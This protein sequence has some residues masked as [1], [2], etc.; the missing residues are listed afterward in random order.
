MILGIDIGGTYSDGVLIKDKQIVK[1]VKIKTKPDNLIES[2]EGIKK[3]AELVEGQIKKLVVSTTL[4]TNFI[5]EKK[6][7][8]TGLLLI[9][10]PGM[11]YN[12]QIFP[13]PYRVISGGVDFQGRLFADLNEK[14]VDLAIRELAAMGIKRISINA[15]FSPRNP[16]LEDKA[17]AYAEKNF[18]NLSFE[19]GSDLTGNLNFIRRA[20]SS[21]LK[22]ASAQVYQDFLQALQEVFPQVEEIR[23]LKSD[24]GSVPI[25]ESSSYSVDTIFSGPAASAFGALALMRD[26]K[27]AVVIDI[28]GTTSDYSLILEGEPLFATKGVKI[29]NF[30]TIARG[31]SLYSTPLGGDS[32]IL[33]FSDNFVFSR[34]RGLPYME[35]GSDL[36]ISDCLL[37]LNEIEIGNKEMALAGL[38]KEAE[39]INLPPQELAE[40]ILMQAGKI[41]IENLKSVIDYWEREPKYR[42]WQ[43]ENKM[44]IHPDLLFIIGGPAKGLQKYIEANS[45]IKVQTDNRAMTANALGAALAKD[46][47]NSFVRINTSEEMVSTGWGYHEEKKFKGR[48]HPDEASLYALSIGKKHLEEKNISG[49]LAVFEHEIFSIVRH[50]YT[51]GQIHEIQIGLPPGIRGGIEL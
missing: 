14:E 11:T 17:L 16:Y 51:D 40:K 46:S 18:P 12:D 23:I 43:I 36:T 7:D 10:G 41:I 48:I 21:G 8:H 20:V 33:L 24:G 26:I 35:G 25:E 38:A 47:F 28:G 44:K 49:E 15:K 6:Y 30:Y 19:K 22:M 37:C 9:P 2:I 1:Q 50:G 27:S 42:V 3:E 13:F 32:K 34:E 4:M 29:D 39:K 45:K 5:V 31:L